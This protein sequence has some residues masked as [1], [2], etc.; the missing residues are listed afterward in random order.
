MRLS[1]G[2]PLQELP[3]E[4]AV[5]LD[6]M[7][8]TKLEY[9]LPVLVLSCCWASARH[10]DPSGE[11]LAGLVPVL[12]GVVNE[13]DRIGSHFS[14]GVM[15]D[16]ASLP[17]RGYSLGLFSEKSDDRSAVE[18]DRFARGQASMYV[19]YSS[20]YP[21]TIIMDGRLPAL[22]ENPAPHDHRAWC[23]FERQLISVA[24]HM[25]CH[26]ELSRLTVE[27]F[28][29]SDWPTIRNGCMAYRRPPLAPPV[30]EE[31]LTAGVQAESLAAGTGLHLAEHSD[32]K[33]VL[34]P[35]YPQGLLHVIGSMVHLAY[36]NQGWADR[37]VML[38]AAALQYTHAHGK[39][40][41]IQVLGLDD[42]DIGDVG[43]RALSEL[44]HTGALP[45]LTTLGLGHNQIGN[46]GLVAFA[47]AL[48]S[49]KCGSL[50]KL[51]MFDNQIGDEGVIALAGA[52]AAGNIPRLT[53]LYL[54]M[55]DIGDLGLTELAN[56]TMA[57][58]V[59][60]RAMQRLKE[61]RLSDNSI[62]S[63]GFSALA[64]AL[65]RGAL[66]V[67]SSLMFSGNPG[68]SKG[69]QQALRQRR[70]DSKA[71]RDSRDPQKRASEPDG[72]LTRD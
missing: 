29:G 25:W 35:Q 59:T 49:G 57:P 6:E 16:I 26:L 34:L 22:A 58:V 14:W 71:A 46:H 42:N 70:R 37:D 65:W 20:M 5:T 23:V 11:Q 38:C 54:D 2:W 21:H 39:N 63:D 27:H 51:Y 40:F 31:M 4:A 69:V 50:A 13:C 24:S 30:F 66:P 48:S 10:P 72:L 33:R 53:H 44:L 18:L 60:T 7:K 15:W 55:N 8:R 9:G 41:S 45:A 61:L 52:L 1:G 36:G 17:Q 28:Q 67:C 47:E 68:D 12:A 56:S 19:W 32:L 62:G 64:E 3:P 43:M